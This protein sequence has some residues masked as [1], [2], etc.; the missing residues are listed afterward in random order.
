MIFKFRT[1]K[2]F[3]V[4]LFIFGFL[5][6]NAQSKKCAIV[7]DSKT[8]LAIPFATVVSSGFGT[9][10]DTS[11]TFYTNENTLDTFT[12]SSI[13]YKERKF[14]FSESLKCDTIFLEPNPVILSS[15]EIGKYSWMSNSF[16]DQ[17]GMKDVKEIKH[18]T[19]VIEGVTIIKYFAHPD[20]SK[21][22]VISNFRI[23]VTQKSPAYKPRKIRV[24][25]F[26]PDNSKKPGADIIQ[27]NE[28]LTIY[29]PTSDYIEIDL[30]KYHVI[31]PKEGYFIGLE[32]LTPKID[33]SDAGSF[34]LPG[35]V[36]KDFE[37]GEVF[38]R[39]YTNVFRPFIFS[40]SQK[41]N[42]FFNTRLYEY[43]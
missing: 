2:C 36:S 38:I 3:F 7:L 1:T 28:I 27:T 30:N 34:S 24:K 18:A 13:G 31:A 41:V 15:I 9:Y 25:I 16:V 22:Y 43:K 4:F 10:T 42:V 39:Y 19:N 40:S 11:G 29:K 5:I 20:T 23:R 32:F 17:I 33:E 37:N 14:V 12:I 8:A 35:K 6:T 21:N 26:A